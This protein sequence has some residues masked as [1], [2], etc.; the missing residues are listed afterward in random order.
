MYLPKDRLSSY[1]YTASSESRANRA[2]KLQRGIAYGEKADS[3][4]KRMSES[5]FKAFG[6]NDQDEKSEDEYA[7]DPF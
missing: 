3:F 6:I 7:N 4:N 5:I 2:S 1:L